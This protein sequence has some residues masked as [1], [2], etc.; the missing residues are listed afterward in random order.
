MRTQ[1][2]ADAGAELLGLNQHRYQVANT[3]YIRA[4]RQMFPRI[5]ARAPGALFQYNHVQFIAKFRLG[6]G[7]LLRCPY[8]SLV[9]AEPSL[10]AD[11]EK[12]EYIGKSATN[13]ALPLFDLAA[14]PKIRPQ[15]TDTTPPRRDQVPLGAARS[16]RPIPT[17]IQTAAAGTVTGW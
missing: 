6:L 7:Q 2:F 1:R 13:L 17:W 3:I 10:D 14:K 15:V 16:Q 5:L 4:F 9:K 8:R 11:D 12:I